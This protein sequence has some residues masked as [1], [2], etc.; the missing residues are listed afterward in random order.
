MGQRR[1]STGRAPPPAASIAIWAVQKAEGEV[2]AAAKE[3]WST[4][5]PAETA[6]GPVL[7]VAAVA[8]PWEGAGGVPDVEGEAAAAAVEVAVA[9]AAPCVLTVAAA[10]SMAAGGMPAEMEEEEVAAL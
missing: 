6:A 2:A 10:A 1:S 3:T 5:P 7:H 9:A 8:T 4:L